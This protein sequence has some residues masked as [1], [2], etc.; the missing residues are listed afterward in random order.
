MEV[1]N[2]RRQASGRED[3][4][5]LFECSG[6]LEP[7][8]EDGVEARVTDQLRRDLPGAVVCRVKIA[9]AF[10]LLV[11]VVVEHD[12]LK[13]ECLGDRSTDDRLYLVGEGLVSLVA[14]VEGVHRVD[15]DLAR[16]GPHP[17]QRVSD[18]PGRNRDE[19]DIGSGSV[20]TVPT[21]ERDGMAGLPPAPRQRTPD[22]APADGRDPHS[23]LQKH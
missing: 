19:N 8:D 15:H 2:A 22:V 16:D 6:L 21:D 10:A 20:T 4:D 14:T 3:R 12:V 1:R 23:T 18:L 5:T 17:A 11:D 7:A 9:R 13:V